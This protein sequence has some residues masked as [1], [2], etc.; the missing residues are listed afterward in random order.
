MYQ[1]SIELMKRKG[2]LFEEGLSSSEVVL[3]EEIYGFQFPRSLK[4]FLMEALPISNG[5]YNWRDFGQD[6]VD[7]I[8]W[9]IQ[10]SIKDFE[11]FAAEVDWCEVW[12]DEP[13]TQQELEQIIR[14]RVKNAPML[15]PIYSHRYI[16]AYSDDPPVFS[17]HG[18]DLIYYGEDLEQYL[19]VEFG[20]KNQRQ[21]IMGNIEYIPFWSDIV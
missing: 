7:F 12:G 2:V 18:V 8:R 4:T 17:V 1:E 3:I 5:F 16:P 21:L 13:E 11:E 10:K 6:N 19:Q 15:I 9:V 20:D 14:T